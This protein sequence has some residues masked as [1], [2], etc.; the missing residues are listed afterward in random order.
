MINDMTPY[1]N[2]ITTAKGRNIM[3]IRTSYHGQPNILFLSMPRRGIM[4]LSAPTCSVA[5][6]RITSRCCPRRRAA[7][8]EHRV[9]SLLRRILAFDDSALTSAAASATIA[10]PANSVIEPLDDIVD[11]CQNSA[12][13]FVRTEELP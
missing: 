1:I 8:I 4:S 9:A 12:R 2:D 10:N 13:L 7:S 11:A 6:D 3:V 5:H